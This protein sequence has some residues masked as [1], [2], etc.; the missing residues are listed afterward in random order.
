MLRTAC[1]LLALSLGLTLTPETVDARQAAPAA[2]VEEAAASIT[3]TTVSSRIDFLASDGLRGRDTPS[4]GLEAAAAYVV[5]EYRRIG[6]EPAGEEG[7]YQRFP[8]ELRGADAEASHIEVNGPDGQARLRMGRD[9][10]AL[11]FTQEPVDGRLEGLEDDP[12]AVDAGQLDLEGAVAVFPVE[13][14]GGAAFLQE[15]AWQVAAAERAGA[16]AVVHVLLDPIWTPEAIDQVHGQLGEPRWVLGGSEGDLPRFFVGKAMLEDALE[17]AG[18]EL[19]PEAD[20]FGTIGASSDELVMQ[21]H[22]AAQVVDEADPPNVIGL[23]EGSDQDLRDEY[24]ALSAHLDHVGVG[25]PQNGDSIYN[26]ADDNASGTAALMEVARALA[27]LEPEARP[28]RSVLLVHVSAEEK[29]LLGSEWWV[30]NPTV[31]LEDVVANVNADMIAGDAH[32]D[33]VMV[34]GK[35]YSELGPLVRETA[36]GRDDVRLTASPD[37][38]P[39]ENLFYRS[40]QYHF[41]RQE[42]P[43][44]FLFT[45]LHECYHQPC[46]TPDFVEP[47]KAAQVARLLFHSTVRIADLPTRPQWDPAGLEEV[48]ERI[49]G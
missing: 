38:L 19:A 31:P 16:E 4:P 25:E 39:E 43:S 49:G 12:D 1:A 15:S 36:D 14:G 23:V 26:G 20:G 17:E 10:F 3:P 33:T 11:G 18:G 32:P 24:V 27:S 13:G 22:L 29:G 46:D 7:F 9:F 28:A 40:D 48:R 21:G 41:M 8:F 2:S 34:M 44:I 45:G 6:V 42:I 30:E 5:S 37:L 47:E 35:E